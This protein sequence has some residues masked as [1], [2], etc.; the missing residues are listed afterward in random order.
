[1]GDR[2]VLGRG[3]WFWVGIEEE[4]EEEEEEGIAWLAAFIVD[5]V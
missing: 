2:V 4:E 1:M 3:F 5:Y